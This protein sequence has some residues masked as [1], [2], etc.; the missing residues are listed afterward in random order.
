MTIT[1][2]DL[3]SILERHRK[4]LDG[5][6]A[7]ERANLRGANLGGANLGGANL[8]DANL[9]GAYL[10]CAN[11]RGANLGGANLGDANLGGAYLGGANLRG[12]N[13]GGAN[14]RGANLGGAYL[15]GGEEVTDTASI[16]FTGHGE[17]GRSLLAVKSE[18]RILLWCGCF[19]GTPEDLRAYID[20][21]PDRLKRTRTLALD[22]V[23]A[24]LDA[25]NDEE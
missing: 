1:T 15:R 24:L 17:C 19:H 9:G 8:G 14:L 18:K 16:Q 11:L 6:P 5:D 20:N 22:T 23:L 4:W 21:G 13:L 10:R 2:Q 12:A 25:K 7:G 3:Q